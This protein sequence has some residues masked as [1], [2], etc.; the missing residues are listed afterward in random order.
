MK[1]VKLKTKFL[2]YNLQLHAH[3]G[4]GSDTWN[5]LYHPPCDKHIVDKN[6]NGKGIFS[7]RVFNGYIQNN[8]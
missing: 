6:K 1:N 8:K 4:S 2:E 7:S 3:N 5:I